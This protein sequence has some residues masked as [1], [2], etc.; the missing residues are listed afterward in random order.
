MDNRFELVSDEQVDEILLVCGKLKRKRKVK[1]NCLTPEY[2]Q[3]MKRIA[4]KELHQSMSNG[5]SESF[6]T[7]LKELSSTLPELYALKQSFTPAMEISTAN[8]EISKQP[9][10]DHLVFI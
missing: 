4:V 3:K 8:K 9:S 1:V 7:H 6:M 5:V 2:R 10:F